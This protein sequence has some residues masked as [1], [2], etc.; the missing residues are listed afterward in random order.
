LLV[1]GISGSPRRGGNTE[2]LLDAALE[3]AAEAAAPPRGTGAEV[4]KFV[5]N[6]LSM[7]PCQNCGGCDR[8]GQCVL[9]DDMQEVLTA[10]REAERIVLATP[11]HFGTV[12]A[13]MKAVIDRCQCMWVEKYK[14]GRSPSRAKGKR[15]G[16]LLACGGFKKG[17]RFFRAAEAVANILF[18]CLDVEYA[19]GRFW[20]G[21]DAKGA[22][23]EVPGALAEARA[24]GAALVEG[25]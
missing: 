8:T 3:G 2:L 25:A 4:R 21:V 9:Q 15:R 17:E 16:T 14:L 19:G 24:A 22:I 13:Q 7:R 11:I 6:E 5:A 1:V 12:T 20:P 23:R 10:L 18:A